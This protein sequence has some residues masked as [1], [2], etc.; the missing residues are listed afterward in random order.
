M[1]AGGARHNANS[2]ARSRSSPPRQR[3][4][5]DG[6][7]VSRPRTRPGSISIESHLSAW[8]SPLS[9][10]PAPWRQDGAVVDSIGR[11][12]ALRTG[13]AHCARLHSGNRPT[14]AI[15]ARSAPVKRVHQWRWPTEMH[16][17]RKCDSERRRHG[18]TISTRARWR[19]GAPAQQRMR[20]DWTT[21]GCR[22]TRPRLPKMCLAREKTDRRDN[23]CRW[24]SRPP[25]SCSA[26]SNPISGSYSSRFKSSGNA[27]IAFAR[28]PNHRSEAATG[29]SSPSTN[30]FGSAR[31]RRSDVFRESAR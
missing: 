25:A 9:V 1:I 18:T 7:R 16:A 4:A 20:P 2:M 15:L 28:V 13:P 26:S 31:P 10:G 23:S 24:E 27:A 19:T 14:V 12:R 21:M 17:V 5:G 30:R 11:I 8:C 3:N 29:R 22:M 6:R